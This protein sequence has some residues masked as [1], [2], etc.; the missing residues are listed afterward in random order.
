[1]DIRINNR[2]YT[3]L[4]T[5][6]ACPEQYDVVRDG[7][8][9]GYLRPRHGVF[10][11]DCLGCLQHTVLCTEDVKGD[12]VFEY[13]ER[14]MWLARAIAEIDKYLLQNPTV[15]ETAPLYNCADF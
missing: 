2:V 3:L 12:G 7:K 10:R 1:M 11:A 15:F 13:D 14:T 8:Q 9:V 5:C 4:K 6:S